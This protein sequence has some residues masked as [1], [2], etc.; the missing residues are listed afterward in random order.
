MV[1]D[2]AVAD[3]AELSRLG[4]VTQAR[5]TQIV[6][7]L[8]LS[9]DI[10]EAILFVPTSVGAS[11]LMTAYSPMGAFTRCFKCEKALVARNGNSGSAFDLVLNARVRRRS[12]HYADRA[13]WWGV[14]PQTVTKWRSRLGI[15]GE[16]QQGTTRLR[17]EYSREPWAKRALRNMHATA[18]DPIRC[19][20]IAESR[21]GKKRP[22]HVVE[23]V[24]KAHLGKPLAVE[25]RQKMSEVHKRRGTR[26]PWLGPAWS[27]E[28]DQLVMT[29][30][31]AEVVKKTGRTVSAVVSR[32]T[33]LRRLGVAILDGRC[34]AARSA[35]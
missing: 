19:Q 27:A 12:R 13:Y 21:R 29:L 32:R 9:L 2:G 17:G 33:I 23:A 15:A 35:K 16:K 7:L 4:H 31:V 6:N 28:E 10:Q 14:S 24:R 18:R 1:P 3:Q 8:S 26:P 11:R 34:R 22:P 5:L 20:K 30:P 25:T